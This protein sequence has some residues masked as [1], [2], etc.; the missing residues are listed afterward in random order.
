[1][2]EI[3]LYVSFVSSD[4]ARLTWNGKGW[5]LEDLGS[6]NGTRV[7]GQPVKRASAVKP[8]DVV[9]IGRVKFK[10]VAL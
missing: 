3:V 1:V 9:E 2:N 4:H 10:L 6:T 7:N 8:G 5:V